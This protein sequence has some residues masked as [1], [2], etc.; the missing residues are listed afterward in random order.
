MVWH[1]EQANYWTIFFEESTINQQNYLDMLK[2]LILSIFPVK[3]DNQ[4]SHA[5]IGWGASPFLEEIH[6]WLDDK[7]DD[8]WLGRCRSISWTPRSPDLNPLDFSW[9]HIKSNIRI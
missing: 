2:K 7:F 5:S 8:R 6:Y 3:M 9:G 4:K 1:V